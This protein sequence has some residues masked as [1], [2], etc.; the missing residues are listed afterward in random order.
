M[1]VQQMLSMN[2]NGITSM[3]INKVKLLR[4]AMEF[5]CGNT[6]AN[7]TTVRNVKSFNCELSIFVVSLALLVR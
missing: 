5:T 2:R 1:F 7:N 3:Y 6:V 4:N